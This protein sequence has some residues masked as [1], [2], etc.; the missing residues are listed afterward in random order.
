MKIVKK[1]LSLAVIMTFTVSMAFSAVATTTTAVSV[2]GKPDDSYIL[3]L[4]G[5]VSDETEA[6][7]DQRNSQLSENQAE[8]YVVTINSTGDDSMEDF[9]KMIFTNWEIG[10]ETENGV[11]FLINENTTGDTGA[12]YYA[13]AGIG[14]NSYFGEDVLKNLIKQDVEP[15]FALADYD[16]AVDS[17]VKACVEELTGAESVLSDDYQA[18][19]STETTESESDGGILGAIFGFIVNLFLI[20]LIIVVLAII[21]L[22]LLNLRAQNI[23]KKRRDSRRGTGRA[24]STEKPTR[25]RAASSKNKND[26]EPEKP[27]DN[28]SKK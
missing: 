26:E 10:G 6:D 27:K 9:A 15:D 16:S 11:L 13:L 21:V 2:P 8:V 7:V 24:N 18:D 17:F 12:T 1:L 25:N 23:R 22:V 28:K 14:L 3:D 20:V 5:I 4:A 19:D